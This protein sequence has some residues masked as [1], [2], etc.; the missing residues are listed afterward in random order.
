MEIIYRR[1]SVLSDFIRYG[2]G[3]G[4]QIDVLE[5][6]ATPAFDDFAIPCWSRQLPIDFQEV[7]TVHASA[8]R[9]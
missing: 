4:A 8:N 5:A 6:R 3:Y 9:R 1:S 2:D 7:I